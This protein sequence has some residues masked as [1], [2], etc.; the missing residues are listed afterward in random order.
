MIVSVN[1]RVYNMYSCQR[2]EGETETLTEF[3]PNIRHASRNN[4]T[5]V[6]SGWQITQLKALTVK[7]ALINFT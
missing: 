5:K 4:F 6:F 1:N 2:H 7:L 3:E